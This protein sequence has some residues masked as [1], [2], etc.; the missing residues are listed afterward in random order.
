[1]QFHSF[2]QHRSYP[3]YSLN[4]PLNGTNFLSP[5][6]KGVQYTLSTYTVMYLRLQTYWGFN[7]LSDEPGLFGFI[8]RLHLL[9]N[10][11]NELIEYYV[12]RDETLVGFTLWRKLL[13]KTFLK[14]YISQKLILF[15]FSVISY[16]KIETLS[17]HV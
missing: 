3:S 1:M 12:H 8:L 13:T 16:M 15:L 5:D 6:D 4:R 10:G 11:S 2:L 17:Q 14:R 7:T 9:G